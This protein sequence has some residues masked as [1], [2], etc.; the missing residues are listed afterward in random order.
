VPM[1]LLSCIC[2]SVTVLADGT[3]SQSHCCQHM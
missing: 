3:K 1:L 2:T